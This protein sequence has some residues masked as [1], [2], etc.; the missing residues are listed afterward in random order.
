MKNIEIAPTYEVADHIWT[1]LLM[2]G[3]PVIHL[4]NRFGKAAV[5]LHGAHV[6]SYVPMHQKPV[7]FIS[8]EAIYKE[9]KAIRGGIPICWPW[10]NAHPSDATLPSHGYARNQFWKI[11]GSDHSQ[12]LTS[13]TLEII[14]HQLKVMSRSHLEKV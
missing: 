6:I 9:G 14:H 13:I 3:Y 5:A 2:P 12:E 4:S 1:Y 8:Q 11:K 7:I 10:F